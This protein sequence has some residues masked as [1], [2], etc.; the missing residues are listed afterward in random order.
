MTVSQGIQA[1]NR[2]NP[3]A[4]NIERPPVTKVSL[5]TGEQSVVSVANGNRKTDEQDKKDLWS[6]NRD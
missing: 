1:G 4:D 6:R 2:K 5:P 3:G